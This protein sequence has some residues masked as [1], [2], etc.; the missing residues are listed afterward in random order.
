M[1][2]GSH[3]LGIT[4]LTI[5]WLALLAVVTAGSTY[6]LLAR[7]GPAPNRPPGLTLAIPGPDES[8]SG[9]A[10]AGES[11]DKGRTPTMVILADVVSR[12]LSVPTVIFV[13]GGA[14]ISFLVA[15]ASAAWS[16]TAPVEARGLSETE[17]RYW[18]AYCPP[19]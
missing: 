6:V 9:V 18:F 3:R 11:E 2:E 7:Q 17:A 12:L 1:T 16:R 5:A 10:P 14:I 19:D 4:P 15:W 8:A 13:I